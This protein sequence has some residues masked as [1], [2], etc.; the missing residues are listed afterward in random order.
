MNIKKQLKKMIS[1]DILVLD[2]AT[3]TEL[4]KRGMPPGVCPEAWCCANPEKIKSVHSAY[5]SAGSRIIYSC[6]F[7]A[8]RFKLGQYD[9]SQVNSVNRTLAGLACQAAGKKALVA[10][11]IGPSGHFVRPFG[12]LSFG[13][14]VEAFKEQVSG[15]LAGGVD[16][17]VVETMMDIQEARAALVAIRELTAKFVIVTMT[18]EKDGRTLNGTD[19]LAALVTLQSLGADAFGCNCSTGPQEMLSLIRKIKPYACVPLVAKPNAGL[20]R[21]EDKNTVFDMDPDKFASFAPDFAR[22]GVNLIGGCCGTSPEHISKLKEKVSLYSPLPEA[23]D[24]LSAL[25][26]AGRALVLDKTKG[27]YVVGEKINPTGKK[28]L[29]AQLRAAKF[30]LIRKMAKEQLDQGADLLDVNVGLP[31]ADEP[32]LMEEVLS[33]LSLIS[34]C[35]LVID[36]SDVLT[37]ESALRFYP[38]RAL[39]NSVSAEKDK[40]KKLFSLAARYGAMCILLPLSAKELP[41]TFVRRKEIIEIL[42][43]QALKHGLSRDDLIVDAIAL[44]SSS[45][46]GAPLET[47]ATIEWCARDQGLHTILGLSNVSFGLPQRKLVNAAFLDLAREKG[48]SLAIMNPADREAKCIQKAVDVL[49]GLDRDAREY[50][51]FCSSLKPEALA[52]SEAI[53]DK[54]KDGVFSAIVEGNREEIID[55][56]RNALDSGREVKS[57]LDRSMIPAISH[58]GELFD[59]KEYFLPQLIASAETM[60]KGFLFLEPEL[61]KTA[62]PA[63]RKATVILATVEGDIHDIGKNIVALLLQN[64]GFKVIDLG[65]DVSAGKIISAIKEY[66]PEV[67]G[68]SALMTTTMVKMREVIELAEKEKIS[69]SFLLGGAVVTEDFASSLGAA[70]ARDG[71]DAVRVVERLTA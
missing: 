24:S 70:Y 33:L 59:K 44:A 56:I 15:L 22:A 2:G 17:F 63:A 35:P 61:K 6:T 38:G 62:D 41:K 68:L 57:L 1:R 14:A 52:Q 25:S 8:N 28:E 20:P 26:S 18:F 13:Q 60:K 27:F 54:V 42:L 48:L 23:C 19:P 11:D 64:H 4:Q 5:V 65:N 50:I 34:P 69:C 31:D 67:V 53:K 30:S 16:L 71:V 36:S 32:A 49:T 21:L 55:C 43:N 12:T 51:K 10:G 66:A 46:P 40:M 9:I 39:I 37:I 45:S 29:Q 7:G 58:V 47:L 3:G